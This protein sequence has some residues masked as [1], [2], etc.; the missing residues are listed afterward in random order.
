MPVRA[1]I[2]L[3]PANAHRLQYYGKSSDARKKA[4][5]LLNA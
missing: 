2:V 3:I 4:L 5:P 1:F